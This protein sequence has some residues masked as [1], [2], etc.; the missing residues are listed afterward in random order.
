MPGMSGFE[1]CEKVQKRHDLAVIFMTVADD[2]NSIVRGLDQY[3]EDYII[4]PA[5][6]AQLLSRVRRVLRRLA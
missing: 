4:K 1:F 6:T 2:Q 5:S 3:A